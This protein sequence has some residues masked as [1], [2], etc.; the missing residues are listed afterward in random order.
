MSFK[1]NNKKP[2]RN[3]TT[4]AEPDTTEDQSI[5]TSYAFGVS[6]DLL[7]TPLASPA[8]R[9]CAILL[10]LLL[11]AILSTTSPLLLAGVAA[12]V[13]WRASRKIKQEHVLTGL[14][15][16]PFRLVASL[17]LFVVAFG[18]LQMASDDSD[19]TKI[20]GQAMTREQSI[21]FSAL[22]VKNVLQAAKV[23]EDIAAGKCPEE[24]A[25][26]HEFMSRLGEDMAGAGVTMDGTD[27]IIN[28]ALDAM[29]EVIKPEERAQLAATV[30][31][32]YQASAAPS[33]REE[34]LEVSATVAGEAAGAI[35][36]PDNSANEAAPPGVLAWL[37]T[38]ATDLGLG[39]GWAACYF[40]V[41]SAWWQGQ[42]PAKRLFG[43]QVVKFNGSYMNLWESFG[44]YGGYCAG[45]ATGLLGFLQIYWDPN[46]QAIQDKISETLVIDLRKQKQS[47]PADSKQ[48]VNPE[49]SSQALSE[50]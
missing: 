33:Q 37:G 41:F 20:N 23:R 4:S 24:L 46:R 14:L 16:L 11:I 28:E 6:A 9:L 7:G 26:W 13:F 12:W 17:F 31:E 34:T 40:T 50:A 10:D 39:F 45:L 25:C 29:G 43:M 32:S 48:A 47:Y 30:R 42:T 1:E 5:V 35:D 15:I 21:A 22:V 27:K 18:V 19:G 49:P 8:K 44:R 36:I 38:L 3:S 2:A